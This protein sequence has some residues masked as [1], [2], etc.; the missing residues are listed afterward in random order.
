MAYLSP[1]PPTENSFVKIWHKGL[2]ELPTEPLAPGKWATTSDIA[3][4]HGKMNVRIPAGLRAGYYLLRAELIALHEGDASY[5][6]NPIRGAQFYPNCVQ[7]E[8]VG[9]GTVALPSTA[10]EGAVSFPGAYSY[11]DPG[12]VHDVYCSTKT[13]TTKP[14]KTEYDI[15]G[16]TV[17]S[18]AWKE[19]IAPE[20]G[21]AVGQTT[22]Q[23]IWSSWVQR[24]V[25][26]SADFGGATAV[27][28]MKILGSAP[29]TQTWSTAYQTPGPDAPW[30]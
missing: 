21:P 10:A 26:T 19:T 12:V 22:G 14:C 15:P 11:S 30:P 1:D 29:Y 9:N 20:L 13:R 4:N 3:K 25:V 17:W 7:L 5:A 28:N 16:P 23:A 2:Y 8:V 27:A 6:E 18:G 24:N